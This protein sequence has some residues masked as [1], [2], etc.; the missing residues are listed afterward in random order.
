MMMS[1]G[2]IMNKPK[3]GR[4]RTNRK[5]RSWRLTEEEAKIV[6][7]FV[8]ITRKKGAEYA[9]DLLKRIAALNAVEELEISIKN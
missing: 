6:H 2:V 1:M 4:P 3:P 7:T 8:E 9:L 5:L